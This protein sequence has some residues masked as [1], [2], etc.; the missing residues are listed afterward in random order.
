MIWQHHVV[1]KQNDYVLLIFVYLE[2]LDDECFV[3]VEVDV[4]MKVAETLCQVDNFGEIHVA[5]SDCGDLVCITDA[6]H[7]LIENGFLMYRNC[8]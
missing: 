5:D 1:C 7:F 3:L 2:P 6:C 4:E 8:S